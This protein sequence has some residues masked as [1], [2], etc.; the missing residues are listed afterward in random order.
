MAEYRVTVQY[1]WTEDVYVFAD[2]EDQAAEVAISVTGW[3]GI[4]SV[5]AVCVEAVNDE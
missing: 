4:D 5:E 3:P 2:S 1:R